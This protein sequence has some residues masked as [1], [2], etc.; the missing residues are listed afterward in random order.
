MEP[1]PTASPENLNPRKATS[2]RKTKAIATPAPAKHAKTKGKAKPSAKPGR[3]TPPKRERRVKFV[4]QT[5]D[6]IAPIDS[7]QPH[8]D[9]PNKG[10]AAQLGES[11]DEN[12][13]VGA[14]IVQASTGYIVAGNHRWRLLKS[15]GETTAP[16][17]RADLDDATALRLLLADNA[18]A[19]HGKRDAT[20]LEAL[21]AKIT[22]GDATKLKGTGYRGVSGI[23]EM[24]DRIRGKAPAATPF[25]DSD[26]DGGDFSG[27]DE[28]DDSP[29]PED[30][31][32]SSKSDTKSL[33]RHVVPIVLTNAEKRTWDAVKTGIGVKHDGRCFQVVLDVYRRAE[34][35]GLLDQLRAE[36][37]E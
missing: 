19:E 35:Q 12:G 23:G 6:P 5:H 1:Q 2:G 33:A 15:R 25:D 14:I 30:S 20:A 17:I 9:N 34:E 13:F 27:Q 4:H 28:H 7:V 11:I 21:L 10:D 31:E 22:G 29:D 26:E 37:G 36:P 8:P 18:T 32:S 3:Q 24:M 16:I